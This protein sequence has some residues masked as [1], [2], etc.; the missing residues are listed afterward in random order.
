MDPSYIYRPI[1]PAYVLFISTRVSVRHYWLSLYN[2]A[3]TTLQQHLVRVWC[4]AHPRHF[5]ARHVWAP[6]YLALDFV[7][8]RDETDHTWWSKFC[9]LPP[10]NRRVVQHVT[11]RDRPITTVIKLLFK[12]GGGIR[13]LGPH[14]YIFNPLTAKLFNWNFHPL[15]VV[16]RWRDPQLQV[17]ENY[18]DLTKWRSTLFKSCWLMSHFI[19]TIF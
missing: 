5:Y 7:N 11:W 10:T 15:E 1:V 14:G 8:Q 13:D 2:A 6:T 9:I 4:K 17:T 18:S 19:F 3:G 12:L 16:S